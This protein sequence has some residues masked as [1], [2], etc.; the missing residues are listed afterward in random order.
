V[1]VDV[2]SELRFLPGELG[3]GFH[4]AGRVEV[5]RGTFLAGPRAGFS[6]GTYHAEA[7]ARIFLPTAHT[8]AD[9]ST[10]SGPGVKV[11]GSPTTLEGTIT[12]ENVQLA[13]L[14]SGTHVLAGSYAWLSGAFVGPG[15]TALAAGS[16]L[17]LDDARELLALD[18]GRTLLNQGT[19]ALSM[20]DAILYSP[21]KASFANAGTVQVREGTLFLFGVS[22]TQPEGSTLLT[23]GGISADLVDIQGGILSGTGS[24]SGD[25]RNAGEIH[26]GGPD[27][28]GSLTVFGNYTQTAF[29]ALHIELGGLSA[30]AEYDSLTVTGTAALDGLLSVA[31]IDGYVPNADDLFVILS[32]AAVKGD[33]TSFIG[34]EIGPDRALAPFFD[35]T[36]YY[37]WAYLL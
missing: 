21:G 8:F 18:G 20:N 27:A 35:G 37:L 15:E 17:T 30:G 29:G 28:A 23:E 14:V 26:I 22:Y 34:L 3:G 4:N 12:A 10:F 9:G 31:L 24:I 7:G 33:F 36:A 1:R 6:S 5:Q 13:G 19:I 32:F 2:A 16:T 25:L 11:V